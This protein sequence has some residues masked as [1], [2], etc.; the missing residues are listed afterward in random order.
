[1]IITNPQPLPWWENI[2]FDFIRVP[3][4]LFRNPRYAGLSS[5]ARML[6]A[7]L[8]DRASLSEANGEKWRTETG[9]PFV[10]FTLAEIQQRLDCSKNTATRIL[11]S[12]ESHNLIIKDRPK[13]DGPYHIVVNPFLQEGQKLRLPSPQKWD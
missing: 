13:K 4:A 11:Q 8:L 9:E 6:Y 10:I 3:K 5:D 12:L 2:Q 7:L 1:M